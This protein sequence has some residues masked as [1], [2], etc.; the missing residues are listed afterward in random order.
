[1]PIIYVPSLVSLTRRL[2]QF[3]VTAFV[4]RRLLVGPNCGW[5]VT[6]P[7]RVTRAYSNIVTLNQRRTFL[8]AFGGVLVASRRPPYVCINIRT[9]SC[10]ERVFLTK[11]I[12]YFMISESW[13]F[14]LQ[15]LFV[16]TREPFFSNLRT[17]GL[18]TVASSLFRSRYLLTNPLKTTAILETF[19]TNNSINT[20]SNS[21]TRKTIHNLTKYQL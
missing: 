19:L 3:C 17:F 12:A 20:I 14:G 4:E 9:L 16:R 15:N 8:V 10:Y 21:Q 18:K 13:T 2:A 11:K 1:M 5:R 6:Y 7:K